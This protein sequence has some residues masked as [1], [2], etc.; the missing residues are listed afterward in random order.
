MSTTPR[1]VPTREVPAADAPAER[2][3]ETRP[4]GHRIFGPRAVEPAEAQPV[5]TQPVGTR[6][7]DP[8]PVDTGPVDTQPVETPSRRTVVAAQRSRFGGI[9]WGSAFFGWL[10]TMGTA[11]LLGAVVTLAAAATGTTVGPGVV[12][13]TVDEAAGGT[14]PAS[15][16]GLLGVVVTLAVVFVAYYCGGY[17]AGRMA[18][19]G[20]AK[21]G[22]AVWLWSIVGS[23][24]VGLVALVAGDRIGTA[25][26]LPRLVV[27]PSGWTAAG[28]TA[29]AVAL[30]VALVGAALGGLGGM[31]FHR[32][33]DRTAVTD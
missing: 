5:G 28:V 20:G 1:D 14:V 21:Q 16:N 3:V 19:F 31:V 11:V 26:G 17:V 8:R 18:R 24:V 4:V 22:V 2:T 30:V 25:Y 10:A 9:K 12:G 23:L 27:D 15:G 32:R 6:P 13:R 29:V 33:V 7:V